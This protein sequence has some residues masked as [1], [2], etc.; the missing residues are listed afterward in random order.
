[1][2]V[3]ITGAAG[4]MGSH[5]SQHLM[6]SHQLRLL[7]HRSPLPFDTAQHSQIEV[8]RADLGKPESLRDVLFTSP[9]F[10]SPRFRRGSCREPTSVS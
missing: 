6:Q 8:C 10:C 2:K 9:G 7:I 5:V 3:L 1:M 4:N